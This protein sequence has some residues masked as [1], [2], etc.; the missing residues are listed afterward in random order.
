L[1][2]I[3]TNVLVRLV[4]RDDPGQY[5]K[6]L[7]FVNR[8]QPVL[9]T[10]LSILELAWVLASRYGHRKDKVLQVVRMLLDMQELDIQ[11]AGVLEGALATW[12]AS[13]ADFADCLILETVRA[14][15]ALPLGTF[16][17]SLGRLEGC[18]SL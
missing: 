12:A 2:A 9:V 4:T 14:A 17:R 16:D 6:A 3:D 11:Q 18:Q 13:R 8:H 1:A 5:R 10:S 7:A 15:S